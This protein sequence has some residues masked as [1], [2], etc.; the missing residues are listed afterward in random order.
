MQA[1][2]N[3]DQL[4]TEGNQSDYSNSADRDDSI[5]LMQD[6][7]KLFTNV[8]WS[9]LPKATVG[10]AFTDANGADQPSTS[11]YANL[12]SKCGPESKTK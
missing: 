8:D 5:K 11:L 3:S 10:Y 6:A 7:R 12:H 4:P 2:R 1:R 9:T